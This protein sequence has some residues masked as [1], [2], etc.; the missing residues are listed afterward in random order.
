MRKLTALVAG[1][2]GYVL[3]A[4]AGRERY[5]QIQDLAM[6]VKSNPKVQET[7]RQAADVAKEAAPVVKDK[8]TGASGQ[9]TT[10]ESTT[11]V[12]LEESAYPKS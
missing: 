8:V 9:S 5:Q 4:R 1:G 2:V 6:R 7:A 3:G 12:P 11:S 10:A